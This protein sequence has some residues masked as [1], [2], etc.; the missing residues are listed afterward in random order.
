MLQCS[1]RFVSKILKLA[2]NEACVALSMGCD[3]LAIA[4]FLKKKYPKIKLSAFHYDHNLRNQNTIMRIKALEFCEYF[5][6][7][8]KISTRNKF[9]ETDESEAGLRTLRYKAMAGLGTVITGHHLD[10]AVENYLFNCF[11]GVPEYLPIPLHTEYKDFNLSV[12]RPFIISEKEEF[13]DYIEKHPKLKDFL[14]EDETNKTE[15]YR[16]NWLRNNLIPQIQDKGY[17]LKTVVRKKYNEYIKHKLNS[18]EIDHTL[19]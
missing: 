8:L 16:R 3:S 12:I 13:R 1:V 10:D 4:H 5:D 7:P 14:V 17:N 18:L 9:V 11:N 19:N 2:N 6:I 15:Q